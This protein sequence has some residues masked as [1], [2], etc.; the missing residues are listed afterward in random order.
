MFV[1]D[2]I[3]YADQPAQDMTV[4][5]VKP[6]SD[7]CMLVTFSTGEPRLFDAA[8]LLKGPAFEP[9]R[10]EAVF[11]SPAIEDGVCTWSDGDIDVSPEFM[12][13]NSFRYEVA[14]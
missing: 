9:L 5:G 7:L 14:I 12:Y 2:G 3:A 8:T 11:S 10:N 4:T 1:I 13:A 6:L